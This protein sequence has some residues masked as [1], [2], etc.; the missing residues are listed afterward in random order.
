VKSRRGEQK[1]G[2]G[3]R[4]EKNDKKVGIKEAQNGKTKRFVS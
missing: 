1:G 3:L 4:S 2:S